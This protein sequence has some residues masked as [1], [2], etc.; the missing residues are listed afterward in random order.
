MDYYDPALTKALEEQKGKYIEPTKIELGPQSEASKYGQALLQRLAA[1]RPEIPL[2]GTA[3]MTPLQS[4]IQQQLGGL[5]GESNL[6]GDLSAAEFQKILAGGYEPFSSPYYESL[7]GEAESL[8]K[9]GAAGLQAR[10][11]LGGT[12]SD[13]STAAGDFLNQSDSALLRQLGEIASTEEGRKMLAAQG[14]NENETKRIQN[15]AAVGGIAE[16]ARS[17]EQQRADAIYSQTMQTVLFPYTYQADLASALLN[18]ES[19]YAVTGGGPTDLGILNNALCQG[20]SAYFGARY[21]GQMKGGGGQQ[22]MS[23][24]TGG[25]YGGG[26]GGGSSTGAASAAGGK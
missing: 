9:E 22:N 5:L 8:K 6:A 15:I 14:I 3:G 16:K 24:Y 1:T 18:Y 2:Q 4:L 10:G 12:E 11:S 7:R 21:G 25:S 19:D 13:T 17:I 23:Q 26:G 20:L